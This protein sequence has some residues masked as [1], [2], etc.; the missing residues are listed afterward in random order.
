MMPAMVIRAVLAAIVA[1]VLGCGGTSNHLDLDQHGAPP[2][3][4]EEKVIERPGYVWTGGHWEWR[5]HQGQWQYG[6]WE[7]ARAGFTWHDGTWAQG[8]DGAWKW[9]EGG[10]VKS[11]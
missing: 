9:T 11:D 4:Q 8:A 6:H 3:P 1:G 7:Q 5:D 2:A 10:W